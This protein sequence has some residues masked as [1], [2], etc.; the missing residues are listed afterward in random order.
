MTFYNINKLKS[1]D[2]MYK[3]K[4]LDPFLL[5]PIAFAIYDLNL[6]HTWNNLIRLG[7][8]FVT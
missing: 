1:I 7:G 8:D 4:H 2:T 3:A 6:Y 5:L